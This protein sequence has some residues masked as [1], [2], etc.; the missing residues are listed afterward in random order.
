MILGLPLLRTPEDNSP[1]NIGS[2]FARQT[3]LP[4]IVIREQLSVTRPA[5]SVLPKKRQYPSEFRFGTETCY[6]FV[7]IRKV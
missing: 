3:Q 2:I 5:N 7:L 4:G 6:T 1:W